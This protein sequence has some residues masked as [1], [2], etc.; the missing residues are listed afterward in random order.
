VTKRKLGFVEAYEGN[1]GPDG[2]AIAFLDRVR[3]RKW[4]TKEVPEALLGKVPATWLPGL[5]H[6]E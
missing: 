5:Q 3:V 1:A 6:A 2:T 4:W